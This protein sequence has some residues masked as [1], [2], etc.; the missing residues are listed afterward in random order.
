MLLLSLVSIFGFMSFADGNLPVTDNELPPIT[1]KVCWVIFGGEV[2]CMTAEGENIQLPK[3]D[4]L[5]IPV[6]FASSG[7]YMNLIFPRGVKSGTLTVSET[8]TFNLCGLK[9]AVRKGTKISII[10][11]IGKISLK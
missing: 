5:K 10:N 8:L 2:I 1:V 7:D 6:E 4:G 11:G 3:G 9:K